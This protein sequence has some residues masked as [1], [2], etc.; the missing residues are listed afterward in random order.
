MRNPLAEWIIGVVLGAALVF[1]LLF[2]LTANA[3]QCTKEEINEQV[4]SVTYMTFYRLSTNKRD[5]TWTDTECERLW[6]L[7]Q[8]IAIREVAKRLTCEIKPGAPEVK[9]LIKGEHD[10]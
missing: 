7:S 6:Q 9:P 10:V 8:A 1:I 4:E 5:F 3:A 2:S